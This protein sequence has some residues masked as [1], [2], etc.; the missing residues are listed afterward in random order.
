MIEGKTKTGFEYKIPKENFDNYE[1]VEQLADA[2]ENGLLFPKAVRT[3]LGKDLAEELKNHVRTKAGI[4]PADK[5]TNEIME[6][7][8]SKNETKNS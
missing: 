5:M 3:L 1:L 8:K 7:F 6:I 4:V 2:E